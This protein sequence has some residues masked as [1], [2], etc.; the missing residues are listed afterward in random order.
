AAGPA[1]RGRAGRAQ[2]EE[3]GGAAPAGSEPHRRVLEHGQRVLVL[4]THAG[5]ALR[6]KSDGRLPRPRG[7]AVELERIGAEARRLRERANEYPWMAARDREILSR[8]YHDAVLGMR[9]RRVIDVLADV[10]LVGPHAAVV[11]E[12]QVLCIEQIDRYVARA[13]ILE[14]D[15]PKPG[16]GGCR[17]A[18]RHPEAQR[19]PLAGHLEA[20][21]IEPDG[22]GTAGT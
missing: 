2:G 10:V 22:A 14:R 6:F 15:L 5:Q 19:L 1:G 8:G 12:G 17:Q 20:M 18:Q 4:A 3:A 21:G 9:E 13:D 7:E 16:R 11:G